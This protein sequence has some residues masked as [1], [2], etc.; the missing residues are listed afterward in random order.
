MK[1]V[2]LLCAAATV[3]GRPAIAAESAAAKPATVATELRTPK[4]AATPHLNSVPVFGVRP[5]HPFLYRIPATGERPM[6]FSADGLPGGLALDA[7]TGQISGS[8]AQPGEHVVTLHAK[9]AKGADE[10]R[11]KIVVGETIALTPAM[12][13]SSWNYYGSRITAE[14]VLANAKAMADSGLI[15]H[16]YTYVNIDDAWQGRRGG[17]FNAIQGNDKF[18][19]MK[20]LADAVHALG[21]KIGIYSTPWV[22]SYAGYIG[23][24]A[25]NPEGTWA[26][27]PNKKQPNARILPW[28]VG[29]Y[30]FATN[31]AKQWSAWGYDYLKYDWNPIDPPVAKEM[32]DALRASGRDVV[33]SLSNNARPGTLIENIAEISQYASSWRITGDIKAN[34]DSMTREAL[35]AD[36]WVQFAKPGH[37][38]DPDMLEIGNKKATEPGLSP[39]ENYTHMTW[40]CMLSAPL[41]LGNDLSHME[42]SVLNVL[43]NDEVIAVDQDE[44]CQQAVRVAGDG[45]LVVYAKKLSDGSTAVALFNLGKSPSKITAN[46]AD[47]KL[48][49]KHAVR[50]LW[51]QK[52]L[53]E[54]EGAFSATVAPHGAEMVKVK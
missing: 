30:S 51:R 6:H 52:E 12:G 33:Y 26:K 15:D 50:D 46:W 9:N 22:Q 17:E 8:I 47:L 37:R 16:G 40:W 5:G 35:T 25:E 32:Y 38:N 13:W 14:R 39:E 7:A 45:D 49:G 31:D 48:E 24:S 10:K 21:L 1:Y 41:L 54:F 4:P 29:K 18:P 23:G 11:F 19:D 42:E 2:L 20:G 34:W 44:L 43:T 3:I 28:S 53:G 27:N 36:K